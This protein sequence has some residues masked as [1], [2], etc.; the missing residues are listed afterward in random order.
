MKCK[1]K[2]CSRT[3]NLN[4]SGFC[5]ICDDVMEECR[6]KYKAVEKKKAFPKVDIDLKLLTE[7][8][9]NFSMAL[10]SNLTLLTFFF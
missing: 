1:S 10:L 4:Q 9:R 6:K 5:N 2:L 8:Q 3:K 7:T